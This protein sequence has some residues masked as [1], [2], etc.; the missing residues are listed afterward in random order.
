MNFNN[1]AEANAQ[2]GFRHLA[3]L[4]HPKYRAD[5]DGLRAIAVLAVVGFHAFPSWITGGFIGVD[6]FFVISGFLISSIIV[7]SLERNS[8]TFAT[9]YGR[10]IRRIFP[11]LLLVL[12]GCFA[13]GWFFLLADEYKQLGKH[14][15]GGSAF[16]SNYI[17]LAESGYFDNAAE[18]KPLLHLWSLGIEEQYY[19][20]W[21]A[22]LWLA[23]KLRF[24]L[25]FATIAVAG[26][27]FV[28]NIA[29][30]GADPIGTFYSPQTRFWELLV[31][32]ILAY[33]NLHKQTRFPRLMHRFDTWFKKAIHSGTPQKTA[34]TLRNIMSLLGATLFML[35][36]LIITKEKSFPGWWALIPTLAGVLIIAAG[37]RAWLNR[38]ILSHRVLVWLGLISFPLY[39][40][41][42]PLLSFARIIESETPSLQIRIAAV[43]VSFVLA[44]LT[45][46][47]VETPIRFGT[48]NRIKTPFLVSLMIGVGYLGYNAFAQDGSSVRPGAQL[49]VKNQGD[50]GHK[51]FHEYPYH[52]FYLCTPTA[53]QKESLAFNGLIRCF[54]SKQTAPISIAI[55]GDSHAEHLFIG[56]A[57]ALPAVNI[58][59]YIKD[60]LPYANNKD[61]ERIF[62]YVIG[63]SNIKAVI[64]SSFWSYRLGLSD[65]WRSVFGPAKQVQDFTRELQQTINQLTATNK[66]VYLAEDIPNF[67]FDTQKCQYS[68]SFSREYGC[69]QDKDIYYRQ[70]R[71]VYPF[72]QTMEDDKKNVKILRTA[73][74]F[75][76]NNYCYM[77]MDG[78]L[79][80]RDAHHLNINGSRY[81]GSKIVQDNPYFS[82]LGA[83]NP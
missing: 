20:I 41:H 26:I 12:F 48:S 70:Y 37:P 24:N 56:L 2:P 11:A 9:F 61:Y 66:H 72:L 6:I 78:K 57:E 35:G 27:S 81:L 36:V 19:I 74:Y 46:R 52:R 5:I 49:K 18:T 8:F 79:L 39:L 3:H 50:A 42:W 43:I 53:I 60:S 76:D 45:Y 82:G 63:D 13:F 64:I 29:K 54:Q 69:V 67:R 33:I 75:C 23:W 83:S 55:I 77:A 22:L 10:R 80:Y 44:W 62:R 34:N 38:I 16:V 28:L 25:L 32:S 15:A 1:I 40:W 58:V 71:S 68:R 59:Y 47:L 7:G 17:F 30:V 4:T 31:G 65:Y 51:I 21:P 14:I 73:D